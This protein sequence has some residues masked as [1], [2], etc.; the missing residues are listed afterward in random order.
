MLNPYRRYLAR[1]KMRWAV[2]YLAGMSFGERMIFKLN[3]MRVKA[4]QQ[5]RQL[6][7]HDPLRNARM[8]GAAEARYLSA[9]PQAKAVM[10]SY[11]IDEPD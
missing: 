6:V 1:R 10:R 7:G 11:D 3:R 4:E 8:V 9:E 2:R 5:L